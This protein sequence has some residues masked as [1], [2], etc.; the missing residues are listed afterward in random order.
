MSE[1]NG[2]GATLS[3]AEVMAKGRRRLDLPS[4]GAVVV[5]RIEVDDLVE[6]LGGLPDVSALAVLDEKGAAAASRKPEAKA[7]LKAMAAVI[8]KG[9]VEPELFEKRK[10][11]PTPLD[12][13]IEDRALMFRTILELSSYTRKVG[14]GVLPLSETAG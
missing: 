6:L 12:F 11:G 7:V 8:Q 5:G 2:G 13:A 4:G 9:T 10:D 1:N 14:E 3:A